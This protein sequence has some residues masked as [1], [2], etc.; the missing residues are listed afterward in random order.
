VLPSKNGLYI[1]ETD[2][3]PGEAFMRSTGEQIAHASFSNDGLFA[4]Q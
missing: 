3:E 2:G 1:N 4:D